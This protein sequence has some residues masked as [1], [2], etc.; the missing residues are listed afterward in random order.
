MIIRYKPNEQEP[1]TWY[2]ACEHCGGSEDGNAPA[3]KVAHTADCPDPRW[4]RKVYPK[5]E[6]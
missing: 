2:W 6:A 1:F 5:S 3:G 4:I